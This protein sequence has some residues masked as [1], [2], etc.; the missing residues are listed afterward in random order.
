VK[1][2]GHY[3]SAEG[4]EVNPEK[5]KAVVEM[6]RPTNV[7][8]LRAFLGLTSYYRKFIK[9][10]SEIAK[11]L[12]A[13]TSQKGDL[14]WTPESIRAFEKLKK[15]LTRTPILAYPDML[16]EEFILDTDASGFAIGA[17]LSQVQEGQER[18]IAYA[19]R[20]LSEEE[21][22]YCTTRREL[23]AVVTFVKHFRPYLRARHFLLRTDHGPLTWLHTTKNIKGQSFRWIL[24]LAEYQFLIQHRA[25][26]KHA[27]ADALSRLPQPET[28][29]K[30][31]DM[32]HSEYRNRY[33]DF[34]RK[35]K[36]K[37]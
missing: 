29:C 18:V 5:I 22:R 19:S 14:Q 9:D 2:L 17:V 21:Q 10:F 16:G 32:D 25:G 28:S 36:T 27:N 34:E 11:P 6:P 13:M 1:F 20:T 37:G 15:V 33:R 24:R 3:V 35:G 31:C 30:D 12:H 8:G 4:V 26:K 23:L 7:T